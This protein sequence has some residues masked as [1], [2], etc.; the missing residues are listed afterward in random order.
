MLGG[1]GGCCGSQGTVVF[2]SAVISSKCEGWLNAKIQQSWWWFLMFII[3]ASLFPQMLTEVTVILRV[4]GETGKS[5]VSTPQ[6]GVLRH[7][8]QR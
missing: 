4:S 5:P 1:R 8:E 6:A 7:G 3:T 2:F